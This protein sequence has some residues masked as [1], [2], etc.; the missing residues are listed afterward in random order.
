MSQVFDTDEVVEPMLDF[1]CG[2]DLEKVMGIRDGDVESEA[3]EGGSSSEKSGED[4]VRSRVGWKVCK[5]DQADG[6]EEIRRYDLEAALWVVEVSR[7]R[8]Y[9]G[10]KW[11]NT[12]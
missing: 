2:T 8:I 6:G 10:R 1:L 5:L 7:I 4:E 11:P 12:I 3:E 9:H